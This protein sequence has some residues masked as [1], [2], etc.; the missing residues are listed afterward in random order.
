MDFMGKE[1]KKQTKKSIGISKALVVD[2]DA[3]HNHC[4]STLTNSAVYWSVNCPDTAGF[5]TC[6]DMSSCESTHIFLLN[7]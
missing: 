2:I 3:R 5:T 4:V 6:L 7:K 1:E